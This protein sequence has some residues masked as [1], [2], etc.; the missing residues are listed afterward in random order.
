MFQTISVFGLGKLGLS[1]VVS[2][3]SRGWNVVGYDVNKETIEKINNGISPIYEPCVQDLLNENKEAIRVTNDPVD[4]VHNSYISFIIVPTPSLV[5]GSFS[6]QFV[7]NA[8]L[9][10]AKALKIKKEYHIVNIT[11]TVLPGDSVRIGSLIE[12][13][14]GKKLNEDFG[15]V[16]NPD[17]IA[18][19]KV[20]WDIMHPDMILIGQS[21]DRAG[22]EVE[23]IH[24]RIVLNSPEIHRM[25]LYN[26]EL[27]KISLNTYC[28]MKINFANTIAEICENMPTGDATMVLKALGSDRRIGPVCLKGG[29]SASGPCFPRDARAFAQVAEGFSVKE[30]MAEK[31]NDVNLHHKNRMCEKVYSLIQE[32]GASSIAILGLSYKEDTPIIEENSVIEVIR[33]L[34]KKGIAVYLYDP[35]AMDNAKKELNG[36]PNIF[37]TDSIEQCLFTRSVCFVTT[38]WKEFKGLRV[39]KF[40]VNPTVLDVWGIICPEDGVDLRRVGQNE[41]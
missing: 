15:L 33:C 41:L 13:E 35:A 11:S 9:E 27:A 19:G 26:A 31:I 24:K 14:S 25:S 10:I 18:L 7:E 1:T 17:F 37:F 3:A 30:H 32:K 39:R 36:L 28:V 5:N 29:L 23:R 20:V 22:E 21:D 4:A 38:P 12:Q 40:M 6:T 8:A 34:S 2:L 16:Y